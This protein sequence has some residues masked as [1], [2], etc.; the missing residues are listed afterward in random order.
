MTSMNFELG[1]FLKSIRNDYDITTRKLG[2]KMGYSHSYISSV[3]NGAKKSPSQDFIENYLLSLTN[4]NISDVNF[5]IEKINELSNGTYMYQ[6]IKINDI[7][8]MLSEASK[9]FSDVHLFNY[10]I[11]RK[12]ADKAVTKE[13]YLEVPINDLNYHLNDISNEKFFRSVPIDTYEMTQINTMINNYLYN[14]YNTQ[15]LTLKTLLYEGKID[16]EVYNEEIE[17]I[18]DYL[19]KLDQ[20]DN[21]FSEEILLINNFEGKNS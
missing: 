8:K 2:E 3:E 16:E 20:N 17:V 12:N 15:S 4:K 9:R 6:T 5:F 1:S 10:T 14:I 13:A 19:S 7:N 18:G 21:M 11:K